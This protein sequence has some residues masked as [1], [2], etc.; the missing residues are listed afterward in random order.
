MKRKLFITCMFFLIGAFG[1]SQVKFEAEASRKKLGINERLRI[2]FIMNKD[3]D[4]FKPPQ[5]NN[6]QVVGGPNQ[7]IS[8]SYMNGQKTYQK[9]YS[10]FLK[11]FSRGKFQIGQAEITVDGEVYKTTPLN[12]EVVAA[13][14]KP[15]DGNNATLT[16]AENIHLVAEVSNT[17]PYLNEGITVQYKLYVSPRINVTNWRPIDNPKFTNFW[18]QNID[19]SQLNVK[20]GTYK[21]EPYRY[22]TLRKTVLYPQKT[23]ELTVEP[24]TLSVAVDV[25][26]DRRDIF[27]RRLY[28][29]VDKTIA[30][31]NRIINV[32]ELPAQDRPANFTGAVGSFDFE[33]NVNKTKLKASESLQAEVKVSGNGNLKLFSLPKLET[34]ASLEVYEPEHI[35]KVSTNLGGMRGSISDTYTIIPQSKGKYPIKGLNFSY[36]DPNAKSY[37]T[38]SSQEILLEVEAAPGSSNN[39]LAGTTTSAKQPVVAKAEQF[40]YIKLEPNLKPIG[41][42]TFF[43]ST[44]YWAGL[45]LPLL[46]LPIVV[47]LGNKQ[48][49]KAGDVEGKRVKRANKLAKKYLSKAKNALGN[50]DAFYVALEKALHNYLRAKLHLQTAEMSKD[51]IAEILKEKK[52]AQENINQFISL[53]QSCELAR[54]AA[55]SSTEM[56]QDYEKA[57]NVLAEL[58]K[59]L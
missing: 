20:N 40:R 17:N 16:A 46:L 14:D 29:T 31:N 53:L 41:K 8:Y 42:H 51:R 7:S 23:G 22:V 25:P 47:F 45:T 15:T 13:V 27:G 58:D 10:Y 33:V 57:V 37:K 24:L 28:E 3:G 9:K 1:F 54:Y 36:F 11:P 6:F 18:S 49:E 35:E 34:P 26:T 2:D 43:K 19:I 5:F 38:L 32:K 21:G 12:V 44:L 56:Q 30:A 52:V 55:A 50:K 48:K 39:Q 4:N 59:Q